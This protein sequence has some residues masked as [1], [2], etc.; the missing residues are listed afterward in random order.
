MKN[1]PSALNAWLLASIT[2]GGELRAFH[3][4]NTKARTIGSLLENHVASGT[5]LM[6]D[7]APLYRWIEGHYFPYSVNH[8]KGDHPQS[9]SNPQESWCYPMAALGAYRL[10]LQDIH[11]IEGG[12]FSGYLQGKITKGQLPPSIAQLAISAVA[13]PQIARHR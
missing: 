2:R 13:P 11:T 12:K 10:W 7:E 3:I 5:N 6:T 8:S 4:P 9:K 1:R